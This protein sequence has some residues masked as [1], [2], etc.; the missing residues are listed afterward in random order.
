MLELCSNSD[1]GLRVAML[2][3]AHGYNCGGGRGTC[4]VQL[5]V[6]ARPNITIRYMISNLLPWI[7]PRTLGNSLWSGT[8][9]I[10]ETLLVTRAKSSVEFFSSI[11]FSFLF[12]T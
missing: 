10:H 6:T 2:N 8:Y 4:S 12:V 5:I 1:S 3:F 9:A 7:A 11:L